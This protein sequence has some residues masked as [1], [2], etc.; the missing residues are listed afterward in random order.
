MQHDKN[1]AM[2]VFGGAAHILLN[3][4]IWIIEIELRCHGIVRGET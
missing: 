1:P 3:T 4:K 2:V